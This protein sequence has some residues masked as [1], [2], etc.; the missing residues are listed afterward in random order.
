MILTPLFFIALFIG[1][2]Y[3]FYKL[4]SYGSKK[5]ADREETRKIREKMI[6]IDNSFSNDVAYF[7][8]TVESFCK[9]LPTIQ[10]NAFRPNKVVLPEMV[11]G[12]HHAFMMS[13][14]A[15]EGTKDQLTGIGTIHPKIGRDY[16]KASYDKH[17]EYLNNLH[18]FWGEAF[19][20][21]LQRDAYAVGRWLR[22]TLNGYASVINRN[23]DEN[24]SIKDLEEYYK[25]LTFVEDLGIL[26]VEIETHIPQTI[27]LGSSDG[28][29]Y[30]EEALQNKWIPYYEDQLQK[31]EIYLNR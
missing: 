15:L 8:G 26:A 13:A 1:L 9:D 21:Q 30:Y 10:S 27:K 25:F 5:Y 6:A 3:G 11:S 18:T 16:I 29:M 20:H 14:Y 19:K 23:I 31:F 2:C 22:N 4:Y 24:K 17:S 28:L 12:L 7:R